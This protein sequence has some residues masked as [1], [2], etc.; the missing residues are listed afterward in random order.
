[1]G[2]TG[3]V[4]G[5]D[6]DGDLGRTALES[7]PASCRFVEGDV[8]SLPD[9]D[10]PGY[11]VVFARL[12]L[13]HAEQPLAVLRRMWE[14]TAP[15]GVL[16]VQDFDLDAIASDPPHAVTDEFRRVCL[17]VFRRAGRPL[18]AGT[19]LWRQFAA[20]GLDHP[21]GTL[22]ETLIEP[23][24]EARQ[25]LEGVHRSILPLALRWGITTAEAAADW[26]ADL[27]AAPGDV[28]IR[29]PL[30]VGAHRRKPA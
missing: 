24:S 5:I 1:V 22:A 2:E 20:V 11:D 30:L 17:A 23:L 28:T 10:G 14:W 15:G 8:L 9:P 16:V 6:V 25:M 18:N 29:W 7:L 3:E 26:L 4:T 12:V 19:R 21:D 27:R 13:I